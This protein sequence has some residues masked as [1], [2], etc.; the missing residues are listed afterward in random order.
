MGDGNKH[1]VIDHNKNDNIGVDP[2]KLCTFGDT[3]INETGEECPL[4]TVLTTKDEWGAKM[5]LDYILE[6]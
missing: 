5:L 3:Y 4:E 6:F 2:F 1:K